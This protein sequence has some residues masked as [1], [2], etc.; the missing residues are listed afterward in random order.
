MDTSQL[1]LFL[2]AGWV[3][4]LTPGPDV[5]YIISQSLRRGRKAGFAAVAGIFSAHGMVLRPK[6]DVIDKDF[7]PLFIS[8]DYFLEFLCC[9]LICFAVF[10]D[11][12][13]KYFY[14][15]FKF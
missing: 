14:E 9:H 3:L 2:L 10:G 13:T 15:Q 8:S 6:E 5:L 12:F 4:N 7:F 11:L 1:L